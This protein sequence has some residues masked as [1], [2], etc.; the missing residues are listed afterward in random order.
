M[1]KL[2][3]SFAKFKVD[4]EKNSPSE[5]DK[6][7]PREPLRSSPNTETKE[8]DI[9]KDIEMHSEPVLGIIM[10]REMSHEKNSH[11]KEYKEEPGWY[12]IESKK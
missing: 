8:L 10:G 1:A 3:G 2:L 9:G 12:Q 6:E 4:S 11:T 5:K 7:E